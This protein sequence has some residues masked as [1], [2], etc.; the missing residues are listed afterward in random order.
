[1][2]ESSGVYDRVGVRTH[3][4]DGGLSTRLAPC[5]RSI[6]PDDSDDLIILHDMDSDLI[7]ALLKD[8]ELALLS[9]SFL[10]ALE[11]NRIRP[12]R[13]APEIG[14]DEG[15]DDWQRRGDGRIDG[16]G[17]GF[18]AEVRGENPDPGLQ[19]VSRHF[20]GEQIVARSAA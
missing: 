11:A 4:R 1:M 15:I 10:N 6:K 13:S 12:F 7:R 3:D 14:F 16:H 17:R 19:L 2:V 8:D 20:P 5:P 18:R 9:Q